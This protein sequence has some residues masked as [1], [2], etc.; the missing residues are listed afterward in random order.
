MT[1]VGGMLERVAAGAQPAPLVARL[2]ASAA[3]LSAAAAAAATATAATQPPGGARGGA[4]GGAAPRGALPAPPGIDSAAAR[5]FLR[6][7]LPAAL[8]R[9][10][11]FCSGIHCFHC[12]CILFK[13]TNKCTNKCLGYTDSFKED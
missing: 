11:L 12:F 10:V 2:R 6:S 7:A 5:S 3:A 9:S 4:P 13:R 8:S 1:V